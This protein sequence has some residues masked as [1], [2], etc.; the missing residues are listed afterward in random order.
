MTVLV[1]AGK[2]RTV[3]VVATV[4]VVVYDVGVGNVVVDVTETTLLSQI[5]LVV[6]VKHSTYWGLP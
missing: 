3:H 2:T 6:V 1:C 4:P 5:V